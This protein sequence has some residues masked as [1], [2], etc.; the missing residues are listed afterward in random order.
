VHTLAK[1]AKVPDVQVP[2]VPDGSLHFLIGRD[3]SN[4]WVVLET[5]GLSG[6]LFTDEASA[7]RFARD[8]SQGRPAAVEIAADRLDFH[9][10]E[11]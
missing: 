9:I 11:H 8:E 4:H 10:T 3:R 5:H 1:A 2:H 6:G 7:L